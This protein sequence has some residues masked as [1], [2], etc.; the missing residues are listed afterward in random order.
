MAATS[1]SLLGLEPEEPPPQPEPDHAGDPWAVEAD[2]AA[3]QDDPA[4]P[5]LVIQLRDD[6]AR[7]RLREAFWISVVVHLVALI[8][9]YFTARL[10]PPPV[11][12]ITAA[13]LTRDHEIT[14]L[15]LPPDSQR[16]A[17]P[18]TNVI[19]DKNRMAMSRAPVFHPPDRVLDSSRA[20]RPGNP[21]QPAQA[22]AS[23]PP[24]APAGAPPQP[25]PQQTAQNSASTSSPVTP[26][27]QA[28]RNPF[29]GVRTSPATTSVE[30]AATATAPGG[31]AGVFGDRGELGPGMRSQA[32]RMG[33]AEIL[34]DTQGVDFAPYLARLVAVVK[35]NWYD[36]IPESARAPFY[37]YGEVVIEFNIKPNGQFEA[38]QIVA[39]SG[40]LPMDLAAKASITSTD[41]FEPLPRDYR[42]DRGGPFRLRFHYFYNP[43]RANALK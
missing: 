35:R 22:A 36:M 15:N 6:L 32:N 17:P 12:V 29:A 40:K 30:E 21:G 20:G 1:K 43:Q 11:R 33:P 26:Q 23:A 2:T 10:L 5:H 14:Y 7:S 27:P 19:S 24:A 28:A 34:S 16:V 42:P 13:D 31:R 9:L 39:P 37:E 3:L 4:V 41:P 38:I 25:A 8:G 18:Q